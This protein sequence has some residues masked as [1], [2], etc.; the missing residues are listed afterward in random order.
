MGV[1]CV[2]VTIIV[3]LLLTFIVSR[4]S[5][6]AAYALLE[7]SHHLFAPDEIVEPDKKS[8]R[9]RQKATWISVTLHE[10]NHRI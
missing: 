5:P 3:V 1:G 6:Q 7:H 4:W 8:C 10:E 9:G 2:L